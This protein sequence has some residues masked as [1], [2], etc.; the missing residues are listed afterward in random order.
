MIAERLIE[1]LKTKDPKTEVEIAVTEYA[2]AED[3][4]GYLADKGINGIKIEKGIV[5]IYCT[6][7][8]DL[9]K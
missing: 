1:I 5:K 3:S 7:A 4:C 8:S 9:E 2:D 6:F